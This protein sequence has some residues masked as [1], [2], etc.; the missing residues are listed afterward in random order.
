MK[1]EKDELWGKIPNALG[2]GLKTD[3]NANE[4]IGSKVTMLVGSGKDPSGR[5][6]EEK[7]PKTIGHDAKEPTIKG[8]KNVERD[9]SG[10]EEA[11]KRGA[12]AGSLGT[13]KEKLSKM[14][15][16]IAKPRR[17]Y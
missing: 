5:G 13:G 4:I 17:G 7:P 8:V 12:Y 3:M 11:A 16:G 14:A 9:P 10:S 15:Q 2:K 1:G 6:L